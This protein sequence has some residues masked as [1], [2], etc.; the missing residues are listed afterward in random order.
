MLF[1]LIL[2][3]P[4]V[5]V[6]TLLASGGSGGAGWNAGGGG[7]DGGR[8]MRM[9]ERAGERAFDAAPGPLGNLT[10]DQRDAIIAAIVG[11]AVVAAVIGPAAISAGLGFSVN[12]TPL[13][14]VT[15]LLILF[16]RKYP[17]WWFDFSLEAARFGGR[18]GACAALQRD[19]YPSTDEAQSVHVEIDYPDAQAL[20]R[21]LPL[22]KWF[23]AIPHYI[24]L[25]FIYVALVFTTLFAW[26]AILVTG[27]YP[28]GLFD[29]AVGAARWSA[30]VSGYAFW[31][32]TDKYPPF[33]LK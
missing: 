23:L 12:A 32:V 25:F 6:L 3:I 8:E 30:R 20:N 1:R 22:V 24:V 17:R 2:A 9:N 26:I 29:F 16:R 13:V 33:S 14:G 31:L 15:A 19:E 7:F 21:W 18:V 10:Q 4:I 27:R 11:F 28:R 5:V